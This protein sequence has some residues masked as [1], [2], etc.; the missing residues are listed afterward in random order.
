MKYARKMMQRNAAKF[1]R[2]RYI[3]SCTG[4]PDITQSNTFIETSPTVKS[5]QLSKRQNVIKVCKN[6]KM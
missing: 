6:E 2:L 4:I 5:F 1:F 3:M